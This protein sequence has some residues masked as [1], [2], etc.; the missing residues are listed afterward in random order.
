MNENKYTKEKYPTATIYYATVA[1]VYGGP[2]NIDN[3]KEYFFGIQTNE[4]FKASANEEKRLGLRP[5]IT[6]FPWET[7]AYE[8]ADINSTKSQ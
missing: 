2:E 8:L 1:K 4:Y 6:I 7:A 5:K 3:A